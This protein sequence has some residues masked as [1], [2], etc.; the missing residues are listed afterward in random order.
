MGLGLSSSPQSKS[1]WPHLNSV[2]LQEG[3]R[4][5]ASFFGIGHGIK[6]WKVAEPRLFRKCLLGPVSQLS[7][8]RCEVQWCEF[9][10]RYKRDGRSEPSKLSCDLHRG[11][12][13][14]QVNTIISIFILLLFYLVFFR[15]FWLFYWLCNC[16]GQA[17]CS[18]MQCLPGYSNH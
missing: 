18:A 13:K 7:G 2:T 17:G 5:P 1:L 12:C 11:T 8:R 14:H 9:D 15:V 10:P 6:Q 16:A 3:T 4:N